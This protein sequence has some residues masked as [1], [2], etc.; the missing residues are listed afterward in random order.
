MKIFSAPQI[1]Q[2]DAFTIKHEPVSSLDLMERSALACTNWIIKNKLPDQPVK[3]FCG[4]GNNGGD[5]LAIARQLAE[6]NISSQVFILETGSNE[7][8]DFRANLLRLQTCTAEICYVEN[9][10]SF[11]PVQK[12]D[13]VIDAL[14]GSGLNR[15]LEGLSKAIVKHI[16]HSEVTTVSVDLPSGMFADASSIGHPVVKA[17][18]TLTFQTLKLAF[19]LPENEEFT[20]NVNVLDIGLHPQFLK[21]NASAYEYVEK[22]L[23]QSV[24]KP[25]K[26]FS[27][28]GTYGHA[29]VIGGSTGKMGAAILLTK[30]CLRSGAGLVTAAVPESSIAVIQSS[31]YEAMALPTNDLNEF[32]VDKYAAIGIGPGLGTDADATD[33]LYKVL[34]NYKKPAVIDADALNI[35]S[36]HKDKLKLVPPGSILTPHPKEHERLFGSS[37]NNFHRLQNAL[38]NARLLQSFIILKG[39]YSF[40]ACPDGRGYFNSTGNPGMATGGSGDVL[41]GI[42]TGLLCQGYSSLHAALLGTYLHGL[43]GDITAS[44]LSQEAMIA[45]DIVNNLGKAFLDISQ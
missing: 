1:K 13:L 30:A 10:A 8:E 20:G 44:E 27:H 38:D 41:T 21:D 24:Y 18:N 26:N 31:V 7:T 17:N 42:L 25:R 34:R 6:Q 37:S 32:S 36:H 3:I 2:W 43:A 16:N 14:F 33:V 39:H 15:P 5:G 28:K 29:L 11:P 19:L 45:G 4:K 40:I 23:I 9:E 35:L 22:P 12:N